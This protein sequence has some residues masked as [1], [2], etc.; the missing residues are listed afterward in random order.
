M[1]DVH[2]EQGTHTT[3]GWKWMDN[4]LLVSFFLETY[5]YSFHSAVQNSLYQYAR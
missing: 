3:F 1:H 2:K 4:Q 5:E